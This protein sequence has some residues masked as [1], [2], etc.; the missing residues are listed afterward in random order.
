MTVLCLKA[1]DIS[2]NSN[3]RVCWL[4]Q[5]YSVTLAMNTHVIDLT[6]DDDEEDV[7]VQLQPTAKRQKRKV[8]NQEPVWAKKRGVPRIMLEMQ[9]LSEEFAEERPRIFD[10][11][12]VGDDATLWRFKLRDFD[13]ESSGG[14]QLNADLADLG[15]WRGQD[16]IVMEVRFPDD[17]PARPF[18]LR[19]VSP[20]MVWYTG[21]VT[22]GGAICIEVLTL[23]SSPNSWLPTHCLESILRTV[24]ANMVFA[25]VGYVRTTHGPGG[26]TGPLRVDLH[27]RY[28]H[29][30]LAEYTQYEANSAFSR[31][32]DHHRRNGW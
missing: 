19:V 1:V 20:R 26:R 24:F 3:L 13:D 32:L 14:R 12:M 25:Q 7:V 17:Y 27:H 22:A 23:S 31:M 5:R 29:D 18:F 28:A 8:V 2:V 10:V 6:Q 16:F 4:S 15:K 11:C 30:V 21:H 9:L